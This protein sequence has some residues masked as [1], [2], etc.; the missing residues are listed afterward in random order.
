M[1]FI[2]ARVS[3]QNI[4][5]TEAIVSPPPLVISKTGSFISAPINTA[6]NTNLRNFEMSRPFMSGIIEKLSTQSHT[7]KKMSYNQNRL[8]FHFLIEDE[9]IFMCVVVPE[10]NQKTAFAFLNS[11][12]SKFISQFPVK[13]KCANFYEMD[14]HFKSTIIQQME[15][16]TNVAGV[17]KAKMDADKLEYSASSKKLATENNSYDKKIFTNLHQDVLY[18]IFGYLKDVKSLCN[19][20]RVNHLWY[21][22]ASNERLWHFMYQHTFG[23]GFK[24][25]IIY[26]QPETIKTIAYPPIKINIPIWKAFFSTSYR[27]KLRMLSNDPDLDY[28]V[29]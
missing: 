8:N 25:E 22:V 16:Y 11:L 19:A 3:N 7:T 26:Q 21:R 17:M 10:C 29:F 4:I 13:W 20:S 6:Y 2:F 24:F 23:D 12:K 5:L 18:L 14:L 9:L 15:Y 27:I 1:S 28:K